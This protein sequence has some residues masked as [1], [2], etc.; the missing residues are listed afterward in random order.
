MV[1]FVQGSMIASASRDASQDSL[2]FAIGL[3]LEGADLQQV[4]RNLAS[5]PASVRSR[6]VFFLGLTRMLESRRGR[7]SVPEALAQVAMST[8]ILAFKSYPHRD[9][10][11]LYYVATR[12]LAPTRRFD[13]GLAE[14]AKTFFPIF[15]ESILGKTISALMGERAQDVLPLLA[16]AYNMSVEGNSHVLDL[17]GPREAVWRATVEPVAWYPRT[18]E[19]IVQGALPGEKALMISIDA[20]KPISNLVEYAFRIRW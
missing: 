19:G 3:G 9:F 8:R 2:D 18:F 16:K 4:A 10:Y 20:Q 1:G 17:T 5:F 6:G 11:K 13:E 7:S 12:Y 14:V 15:R